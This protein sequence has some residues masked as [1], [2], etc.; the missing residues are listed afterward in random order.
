L[1]AML[2]R[3][4]HSCDAFPASNPCCMPRSGTAFPQFHFQFPSDPFPTA[5]RSAVSS[6]QGK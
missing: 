5:D 4:F 6:S 1:R 2:S 3:Q